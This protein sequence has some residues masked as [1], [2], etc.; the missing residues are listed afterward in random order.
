METKAIIEECKEQKDFFP[1]LF[2]NKDNS[3]II[4]AEERTSDK[5]FSGMIIHSEN[6]GKTFHLG[7]YNTGWTYQQFR[8]LPKYSKVNIEIT[9]ND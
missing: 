3:I 5:T 7:A 9:Q 4:L 6:N 8:R 2:A 1:A